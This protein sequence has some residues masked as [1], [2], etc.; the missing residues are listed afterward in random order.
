MSKDGEVED[1]VVDGLQPELAELTDDLYQKAN[2]NTE[3]EGEDTA[4]PAAGGE[5]TD[6]GGGEKPPKA[7]EAGAVAKSAP[8]EPLFEFGGRKFTR[9]DLEKEL[10]DGRTWRE[11]AV[12]WHRK[13]QEGQRA[14]TGSS[15]GEGPVGAPDASR[16]P[17]GKPPEERKFA[18]IHEL[19]EPLIQERVRA[20]F[21]SEELASEYPEVP[22]E[23]FRFRNEEFNPMYEYMVKI[24]KPFFDRLR[25]EG[26]LN[27]ARAVVATLESELTSMSKEGGEYAA[28]SEQ[29]E[30]EGFVAH[31]LERNPDVTQ[32]DLPTWIREQWIVYK[33]DAYRQA[34]RERLG[35]EV[36]AGER[37]RSN[38]DPATAG[39]ARPTGAGAS[40]AG[41]NW[42]DDML[43]P[44][45]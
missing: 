14:G 43:P 4:E 8:E 20:G 15:E 37:E 42:F 41:G 24:V 22:T 26:S 29:P 12:Y 30:V 36:E 3:P 11:Q 7:E 21:I 35:S 6:Q 23:Y 19:Y 28:L 10:T 31:L 38:A 16:T 44:R 32:I 1:A 5:A 27:R 9:A 34:L 2:Q 40:R 13:L 33:S 17:A 18:E 39:G 25:Q 45:S